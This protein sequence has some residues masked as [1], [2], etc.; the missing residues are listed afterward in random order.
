[1]HVNNN[2]HLE[3]YYLGVQFLSSRWTYLL[4]YRYGIYTHGVRRLILLYWYGDIAWYDTYTYDS[5]T[6]TGMG[7]TLAQVLVWDI[8]P[9]STS[10]GMGHTLAQVLVWD[11]HPCS[12]STGMGHTLAQVLVWDIH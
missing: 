7:H 8:H 4:L 11:I 12:T 2:T 9:C 3:F 5:S 10:T 1:M 6:S